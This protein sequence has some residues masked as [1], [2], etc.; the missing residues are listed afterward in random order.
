[1][2]L[3]SQ[4]LKMI[5]FDEEQLTP[6][7]S[8]NFGP[9]PAFTMNVGLTPNVPYTLSVAAVD[10]QGGEGDPSQVWNFTWVPQQ[11]PELVPWPAR[12]LAA[13]TTFD[14]PNTNEARVA[15]VLMVNSNVFDQ[16]YP[17]GIRI[18]NMLPL[19]QVHF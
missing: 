17:V 5:Q 1:M 16:K 12:P 18:G 4:K 10:S 13:M 9:G 2:G 7:I 8:T 15:A 6:P 11:P 14:D 3:F 19:A